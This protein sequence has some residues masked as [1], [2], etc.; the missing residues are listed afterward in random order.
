ME[1][2]G[3]SSILLYIFLTIS[4]LVWVHNVYFLL[5]GGGGAY[6][7]SFLHFFLVLFIYFISKVAILSLEGL[8]WNLEVRRNLV[9]MDME[10]LDLIKNNHLG[11]A[12]DDSV[13]TP[14]SD[15]ILA[16]Y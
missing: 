12:L 16:N 11:I 15:Y 3:I 14:N 8:S 10:I 4:L 6:W 9:D 7:H 1:K 2:F 5:Y 13:W